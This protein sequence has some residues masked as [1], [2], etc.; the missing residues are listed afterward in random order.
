MQV[1]ENVNAANLLMISSQMNSQQTKATDNKTSDA[2]DFSGYLNHAKQVADSNSV[3]PVTKEDSAK[4]EDYKP[5]DAVDNYRKTESVS[6]KKDGIKEVDDEYDEIDDD[7]VVRENVGSMIQK[8]MDTFQL[9]L[10]ELQEKMEL[11]G[12]SP[13][14]LLTVDGLKSFFLEMNQADVSDLLVNEDLGQQLQAFMAMFQEEL[15]NLEGVD[16]EQLSISPEFME[17][18]LQAYE[19]SQTDDVMNSKQEDNMLQVVENPDEIDVEVNV[20]N[21]SQTHNAEE[22]MQSTN[23]DEHS[24][25]VD[26]TTASEEVTE[27]DVVD[28]PSVTS[29][30]RVE[31]SDE[32]EGVY[33]KETLATTTKTGMDT[34]TGQQSGHSD[35]SQSGFTSAETNVNANDS[36]P[37]FVNPILQG[38]QDALNGMDAMTEVPQTP[39]N[40]T[41]VISQIVEQVRVNM[42][43]NSTSMEL[44]LYP[45][46]LGRIQINIISKNGIMT[47]QIAA[48]TES[49]KQ[50]I[51]SGLMNL[52]ES[53]EQQDLKVEAI[54]VMVSTAGFERGNESQD[55]EKQSFESTSGRRT[56]RMGVD[57]DEAEVVDEAEAEVMKAKGSSVSYMA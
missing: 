16:L 49:A 54:E 51:E 2:L 7:K 44:Q 31:E 8:L 35:M 40:T 11:L 36:N 42:N 55:A 24:A 14:Q 1:N 26:K 27:R 20:D 6:S 25:L 52:K 15:A 5:Q 32:V 30:N 38:I 23:K 12:L 57:E 45:E 41:D 47:A 39:V 4:T 10:E 33:S 37:Q 13:E 50:A 21:Y 17:D 43:Q 34:Q 28:E 53:F 22:Q 18:A 46:H 3:K 56:L 48:E 19:L 29:E 9:S